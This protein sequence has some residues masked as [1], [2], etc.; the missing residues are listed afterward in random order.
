MFCFT[1]LASILIATSFAA[2]ESAL[3]V[4]PS[5]PTTPCSRRNLY[6]KVEGQCDAYVECIDFV[7]VQKSCPD[8][9]HYDAS[10]PWPNYPCGYPTDVPCR[11][12]SVAQA[13][14]PTS[15]CPHQYGYYPSPSAHPSD[16]G[17]YRMCIAGLAVD[18]VCPTGLAFN[19]E[20]SRCD[21]AFLVKSCDVATFLGYQC[22]P[23]SFDESGNPVVTNHK[24]NGNC[25]AFYSCQEGRGRILSCDPGLAFDSVSS[26]CVDADRVPCETDIAVPRSSESKP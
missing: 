17:Q 20:T 3:S 7:P 19:F 24:Y 12:R 10:V 26:R 8:G 6:D 25:F 21:W 1:I 22:P 9:L 2:E 23:P 14:K 4:A 15:D 18:M 16:C 11:D 5:D 13:P